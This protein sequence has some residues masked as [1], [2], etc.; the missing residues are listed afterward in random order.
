MIILVAII[1]MGLYLYLD[2]DGI[3]VISNIKNSELDWINKYA[4][5]KKKFPTETVIEEFKKSND[6][7]DSLFFNHNDYIKATLLV[8]NEYL[9]EIIPEFAREYDLEHSLDVRT[10]KTDEQVQ[11]NVWMPRTVVKWLDKTQRDI[12]YTV[13][14]SSDE[15]TRI[16]IYVNYLGWKIWKGYN[17]EFISSKW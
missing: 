9:D 4:I 15:Y 7:A 6:Y 11:Y 8:P 14:Q 2:N 16:Y 12:Y 3:Y 5:Y 10:E 17:N 13:M 1:I